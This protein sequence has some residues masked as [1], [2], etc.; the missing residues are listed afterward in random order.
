MELGKDHLNVSEH[1]GRI[2]DG[3]IEYNKK[4]DQNKEI[5]NTLEKK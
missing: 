3:A 1:F 5:L 4:R 2:R